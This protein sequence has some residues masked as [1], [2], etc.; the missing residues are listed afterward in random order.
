[1]KVL[2]ISGAKGWGGGENQL[3]LALDKISEKQE[4]TQ[5]LLCPIDSVLSNKINIS[6][7][8]LVTAPKNLKLDP[9]FIFSIRKIVKSE[10]IDI[11]HVH[12]PE[13]HSLVVLAIDI[14]FLKVKVVLHKKT[15]F[16]IK[17][18]KYSIYKYNHKSIKYIICVSQASKESIKNN[19]KNIPI[20]V[21]YDAV[22]APNHM[23]I[24][25]RCDDSF[26]VLNIAN[27][28]RHKNLFTLLDIANNCINIEKLP[29]KFIQ[30][31]HG[32]L[33][34]N[35]KQKLIDLNLNDFFEFKGFVDN[36]EIFYEQS[37]AFVFTSVREGL[38]V[39]LLE[40]A[41]N[42]LPIVSSNSGGIP[43]FIEDETEGLLCT[44]DDVDSFVK[45]LKRLYY[46]SELSK[47]LSENAF[48]KVKN[49]FSAK[50]MAK[51]TINIYELIC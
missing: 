11:V 34:V 21:I 49:K 19:V 38:G 31:G 1:M 27:H 25:N 45:N 42:G 18:K 39:S 3:L 24:K 2:H 29:F 41:V 35:L 12:D 48:R 33:S 44:F 8:N 5:Y 46:S 32:K 7:I 30:L 17:N 37:D 36:V 9:R 43:E 20:T 23:R 22:I 26:I 4:I 50:I 40:A 14:F 15:I 6:K 51:K 10:K 16:P 13:A 47:E 28:T